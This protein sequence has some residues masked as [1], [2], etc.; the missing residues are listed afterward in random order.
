VKG[1]RTEENGNKTTGNGKRVVREQRTTIEL[2]KVKMGEWINLYKV[3][4]SR[5]TYYMCTSLA[6]TPGFNIIVS[7]YHHRARVPGICLPPLMALLVRDGTGEKR[8]RWTYGSKLAWE[9]GTESI[10]WACTRVRAVTWISSPYSGSSSYE[11]PIT[12]QLCPSR[13]SVEQSLARS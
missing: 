5:S 13:P 12:S 3:Y 1:N 6:R 10:L 2:K 9:A 11:D 8:K 7:R 4:C